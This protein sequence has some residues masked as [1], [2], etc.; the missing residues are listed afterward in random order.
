MNDL[1]WLRDQ[2]AQNKDI[3]IPQ[4]VAMIMDGNGRY[5]RRLMRSRSWGHR[6][7]AQALKRAVQAAHLLEIPY[8]TL[9]AFSL[10]N[11]G[12]PS[13]EVQTLMELLLHYLVQEREELQKRSIRLRTIGNTSLLPNEVQECLQETCELLRDN[14]CMDLTLALSYSAREEL[15]CAMQDL[16]REVATGALHP[17]EITAETIAGALE[18]S[19]IPDPDLLIRTSGEMRLSNFLLWQVAYTEFYFASVCWPEFNSQVL[20][21]AILSYNQRKRSYGLAHCD[22][23]EPSSVFSPPQK[24]HPSL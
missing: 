11:W 24:A 4:H 22:E 17:S 12:R 9:Y 13:E 10:E 16:A 5:A 19:D 15:T 6:R 23:C 1:K 8:L 21:Q 3:L 20:W 2:S 14:E 18:T 7:G